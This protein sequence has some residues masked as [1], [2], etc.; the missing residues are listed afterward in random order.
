MHESAGLKCSWIMAS[1]QIDDSAL[2]KQIQAI[3]LDTEV[4]DSLVAEHLKGRVSA[5]SSSPSCFS[6]WACWYAHEMKQ[7]RRDPLWS[8][9]TAQRGHWGEHLRLGL[10]KVL[11]YCMAQSSFRR[12]PRRQS[13]S[14][15][16]AAQDHLSL[17]FAYSL[18]EFWMEKLSSKKSFRGMLQLPF[19]WQRNPVQRSL[20]QASLM[21]HILLEGCGLH[22]RFSGFSLWRVLSSSR[23]W[24]ISRLRK[25][26]TALT[27]IDT[28]KDSVVEQVLHVK[29]LDYVFCGQGS[30]WWYWTAIL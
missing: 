28:Q 18:L 4:L 1:S 9:S 2:R 19:A 7:R 11:V 15:L 22:T 16:E 6:F 8:M 13:S 24:W 10:S 12:A 20:R 25:T 29:I 30:C 5:A 23:N 3:N 21:S 27:S 17:F 26:E 14:H